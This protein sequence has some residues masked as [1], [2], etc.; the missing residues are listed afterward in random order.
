MLSNEFK[1]NKVDKYIYMKNK[2]KGY[3]IICLYVNNMFILDSND[4]MAR[5]TKKIS[6]NKFDM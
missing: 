2:D 1:I 4:H 5:S 6:T 3:S